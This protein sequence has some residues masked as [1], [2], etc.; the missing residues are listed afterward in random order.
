[1]P[2]GAVFYDEREEN[3]CVLYTVREGVALMWLNSSTLKFPVSCEESEV[4]LVAIT[5]NYAKEGR[6]SI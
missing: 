1:M 3:A 4:S 6:E 2:C 5:Y